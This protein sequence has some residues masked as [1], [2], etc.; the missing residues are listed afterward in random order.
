MMLGIRKRWY[1]RRAVGVLTAYALVLHTFL[2]GLVAVQASAFAGA[3]PAWSQAL[4]VADQNADDALLDHTGKTKQHFSHCMLCGGQLL[5]GPDIIE[6]G[7]THTI[8]AVQSPALPGL[9]VVPLLTGWSTA[10][11]PPRG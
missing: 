11:A 7:I 5:A 2:A 4:C 6:I 10:R 1:L 3:S 8:V 9:F